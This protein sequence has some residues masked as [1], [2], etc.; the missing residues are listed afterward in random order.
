MTYALAWPLQQAVFQRLAAD[1]GV[2]ALLGDRLY[3]APP[4]DA[5]ATE[6]HLTLGDETATDWSTG[7]GGGAEHRLTLLIHAPARG[8]AEAKQA[9]AAICDALLGAELSLTRGHVVCIGF[10]AAETARA[11]T[12]RVRQIALRFRILVEDTV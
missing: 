3:D 12:D 9:A 4:Q 7:T 11:Q 1:A 8:F 10:L 6:M 2:T 5:A